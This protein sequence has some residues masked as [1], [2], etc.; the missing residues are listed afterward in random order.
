MDPVSLAYTPS[1]WFV[2]VVW[3]VV[4][5]FEHPAIGIPAGILMICVLVVFVVRVV[6]RRRASK[7]VAGTAQVLSMETMTTTR[8]QGPSYTCRIAL[9]VEIPGRPTYDATS[10]NDDFM[11]PVEIGAVRPGET[12]AV[13]VDSTNPQDV[14][15][16]F[17]SI[18]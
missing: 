14:W 18:T 10:S 1:G 11:T 6:R 4:E 8:G 7:R 16:D 17:S 13:Q 12:V 2:G 5:L 3:G 15:I 9:R